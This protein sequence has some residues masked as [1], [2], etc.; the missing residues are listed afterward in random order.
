[1]AIAEARR[2]ARWG[3]LVCCGA[4]LAAGI[5]LL[6]LNAAVWQHGWATVALSVFCGVALGLFVFLSVYLMRPR[7]ASAF[8]A[9]GL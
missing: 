2:W 4:A 6:V 3:S 1:V 8:E 5:V 9:G 7:V